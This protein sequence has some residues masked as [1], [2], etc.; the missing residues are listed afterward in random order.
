MLLGGCATLEDIGASL[1]GISIDDLV[2]YKKDA[3]KK[4]FDYDFKTCYEKTQKILKAMPKVSIYSANRRMIA[5]YYSD[6]NTTPVGV[7]FERIDPTHTQVEVSSPG[8]D[9]KEWVAK[10][11]FSEKVL[12]ATSEAKSF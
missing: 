5:L 4:V 9:A 11:I 1:L 12:P 6:P 2:I 3:L 7:F 8:V 10:N